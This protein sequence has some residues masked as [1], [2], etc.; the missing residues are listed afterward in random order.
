MR[1]GSTFRSFW[2]WLGSAPIADPVDRR[3]A[4]FLQLLFAAVGTI[5]FSSVALYTVRLREPHP[6]IP[7]DAWFGLACTLLVGTVSWV[8]FWLIRRGLLRAGVKFFVVAL[9]VSLAI[10]YSRLGVGELTNDP[11]PLLPLAIG[12]LVL[13]RRALWGVFAVLAAICV[14]S[15]LAELARSLGTPGHSSLRLAG[16][17]LVTVGAYLLIALLLDRTVAALRES[18]AESDRRRHE[19]ER[20][21]A[22][23]RQ[24]MA[25][26]ERAQE[27]LIHAQKMELVGRLASGVA[28]DFDNIINVIAGYARRR[29]QLADRGTAALVDAMGG[30]EI[31]SRRALAIS[32]KLL[33]FSR[34]PEGRPERFDLGEALRELQPMLRQLFRA[35]VQLRLDAPEDALTA[36]MDRDQLELVVLNIAANARDAVGERGR[37]AI[38]C[39]REGD[40]ALLRLADDGCGI[41]DHVLP[42]VFEPFFTTKPA[43]EGTG[44]GLSLV[45]EMVEAAGGR[46]EA[47]S[48]VGEGSRFEI[49]LPLAAPADALA[50]PAVQPASR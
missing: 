37:F 34:R 43:G 39:S 41:P 10:A 36:A 7:P 49:R 22:Q 6:P 27:Q 16:L 11:V 25:E 32:R 14:A 35:G 12:G 15:A 42:H 2:R 9:L 19:L 13:G 3:N 40:T 30:I 18:L 24:E 46:I 23:L 28:H 5:T 33:N 8:S 44:L 50:G 17:A 29:E 26:R 1:T 38:E 48:R 21:N 4:P 20:V 45:R 47:H 31:A